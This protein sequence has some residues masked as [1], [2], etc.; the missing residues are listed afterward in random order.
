MYIYTRT[1]SARRAPIRH[2]HSHPHTPSHPH[3]HPH[4]HTH[5][6]TQ[7]KLLCSWHS[8]VHF[9][10]SCGRARELHAPMRS[11]WGRSKQIGERRQTLR[12]ASASRNAQVLRHTHAHTHTHT[13]THATLSLSLSSLSSLS[14][15]SLASLSLASL[16]PAL[17]SGAIRPIPAP[18]LGTHQ[19]GVQWEGGA[20]WI[21]AVLYNELVGNVM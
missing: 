19:R 11:G 12:V 17:R 13:H 16:S 18:L 15:L 5:T 7:T 2:Q 21:G 4:S 6:E 3:S 1:Y 9:I 8:G 20:Q 10:Y 14:R